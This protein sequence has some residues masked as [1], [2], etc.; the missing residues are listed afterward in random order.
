MAT[1]IE[2]TAL[3]PRRQDEEPVYI[4]ARETFT[5][6][7]ATKPVRICSEIVAQV[8]GTASSVKAMLERC[9]SDPALTPDGFANADDEFFEGD[10]A[11]GIAAR[12]YRD[13]LGAYYRIRIIEVSGGEVVVNLHGQAA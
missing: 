4:Q 1:E 7:G 10:L 5:S 9:P 2:T 12:R 8:S 11:A 6:P 3:T 13:P